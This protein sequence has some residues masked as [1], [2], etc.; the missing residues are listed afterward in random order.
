MN[1]LAVVLDDYALAA[2]PGLDGAL[3]GAGALVLRSFRGLPNPQLLRRMPG[4]RG[5][6]VVGGS[7]RRSLVARLETATA[8]LGAPVIA[9]LPRG[10]APARDLRGP[11]GTL[12][13]AWR[14]SHPGGCHRGSHPFPVAPAGAARPT[15]R[16]DDSRGS[17]LGP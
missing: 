9:A 12:R 13:A 5:A 1:R 15:V 3:A 6:A 4:C 14:G 8:T 17:R 16:A 2:L 11:G 10:V 7:D